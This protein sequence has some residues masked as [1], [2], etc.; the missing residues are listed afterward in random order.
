MTPVFRVPISFPFRSL[1]GDHAWSPRNAAESIRPRWLGDVRRAELETY[2]VVN[3][4]EKASPSGGII[5]RACRS[6]AEP[7]ADVSPGAPLAARRAKRLRGHR[8]PATRN[9]YGV[10][11]T[12]RVFMAKKKPRDASRPG[13]PPFLG[14]N[15]F[16]ATKRFAEPRVQRGRYATSSPSVSKSTQQDGSV[17]CPL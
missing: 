3:V 6:E 7:P 1:F 16:L 8:D 4:R 5:S 12:P 2:P 9:D 14:S 17:S 11:V 15:R 10:I 13:L